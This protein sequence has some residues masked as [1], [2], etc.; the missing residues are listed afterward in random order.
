MLKNI[1]KKIV[2]MA[3]SPVL[4]PIE[5]EV[6]A[7][8]KNLNFL[9]DNS[10]DI[11][12]IQPKPSVKSIQIE[13]FEIFEKMD[14]FFCEKGI[15][16]FFFAGTLLGAIR[17]QSFIPWDDDM[18]IGLVY[19]DFMK[20]LDYE[21]DLESFGLKFSSPYSKYGNYTKEGWHRLYHEKSNFTI[22][23]FVFDLVAPTNIK[24][25]KNKR[26]EFQH[27]LH[28]KYR[29]RCIENKISV[30]QFR[31]GIEK[32]NI[33][34]FK[35]HQRIKKEH[36]DHNTYMFKSISC[37]NRPIHVPFN[38]VFPLV[39]EKFI[40]YKEQEKEEFPIPNNPKPMF[41]NY[42]IGKDYMHFPKNLFPEHF[43]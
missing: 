32:L 7:I 28:K 38:S 2:R 40:V 34:H 6:K 33:Q 24:E 15:D 23:L 5:K 39:K 19:D 27:I 42:Y 17:H 18:D 25:F 9:I 26:D 12:N 20:F 11:S 8:N 3:L 21:D 43:I 31:E 37:T 13:L 30:A 1:Y 16:Y 22:S 41:E 29:K 4:N 14:A 35:K 10:L 36:A